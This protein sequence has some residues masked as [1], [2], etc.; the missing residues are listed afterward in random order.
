MIETHWTAGAE[1]SREHSLTL[2][3]RVIAT[4]FNLTPHLKAFG[5]AKKRELDMLIMRI[6]AA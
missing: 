1:I 2:S 4:D 3:L 5:S 6:K